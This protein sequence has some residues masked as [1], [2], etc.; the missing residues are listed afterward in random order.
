MSE[1]NEADRIGAKLQRNSGRGIL[2]KG[3]ATLGPLLLDIKEYDESFSVSRTNWAKLASDAWRAQQRIPA[4]FLALGSKEKADKLRLFVVKEDFFLEM[5]EAW[6]EKYE[7]P[8][9]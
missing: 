1:K 7:S 5:L 6:K 9:I 3:D 4:F 2:E 8:E